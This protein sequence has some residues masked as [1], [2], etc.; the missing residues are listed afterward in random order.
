[1]FAPDMRDVIVM[2]SRERPGTWYQTVITAALWLG[3]DAPD[4]GSA[5]TPMFLADFTDPK[6]TSDLYMVDLATGDL[7]RLTSFHHV[8]PEF[9]WNSGYTRLLWSEGLRSGARITRVARFTGLTVAQPRIPATPAPGLFGAPIDLARIRTV[10]APVRNLAQ[11]VS[12]GGDAGVLHDRVDDLRPH[13]DRQ[14]VAH[15]FDHQELRAWY[16]GCGVLAAHR[17]NQRI[18]GAVDHQRRR[19]DGVQ[20]RLAAA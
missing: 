14:S 10:P 19:L 5:G 13:R 20:P 6:F 11:C 7:R 18:D 2:T 3:F 15:A 1:M 8:I 16:R 9:G 17:V 12:A 4:P